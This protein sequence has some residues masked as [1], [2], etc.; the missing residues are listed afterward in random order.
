MQIIRIIC[1]QVDR[2][3]RYGIVKILKIMIDGPSPGYAARK[4]Y[5][6]FPQILQIDFGKRTLVQADDNRRGIAP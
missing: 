6:M 5:V 4:C 1:I 2:P 3:P